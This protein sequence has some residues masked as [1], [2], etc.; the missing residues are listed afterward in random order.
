MCT[1]TL[2]TYFLMF[3]C[4]LELKNKR[5]GLNDTCQRLQRELEKMH[6]PQ[7][8]F[9]SYVHVYLSF[10]FQVFFYLLYIL[11]NILYDKVH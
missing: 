3:I 7:V 1:Y 5:A 9:I 4:L 10:L 2:L 6:I 8:Y 11:Y